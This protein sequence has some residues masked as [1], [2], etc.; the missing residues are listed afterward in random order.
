MLVWN[1]T[2]ELSSFEEYHATFFATFSTSFT[3]AGGGGWSSYGTTSGETHRSG[4]SSTS[5]SRATDYRT[6]NTPQNNHLYSQVS[7]RSFAGCATSSSSINSFSLTDLLTLIDTSPGGSSTTFDNGTGSTITF[8][9]TNTI[10]V[11]I[12]TTTTSTFEQTRVTTT[13][14]DVDTTAVTITGAGTDATTAFTLTTT[15]AMTTVTET[16]GTTV[17]NTTGSVVTASHPIELGLVVD[18]R[19][20]WGWR[21]TD[22]SS[23]SLP[24]FITDIG[25]S[26][27]T[28]V[29]WAET[30]SGPVSYVTFGQSS[31]TTSFTA[32]EAITTHTIDVVTDVLVT[33]TGASGDKFPRDTFT[34]EGISYSI[35]SSTFTHGTAGQTIHAYA[36][37]SRS[38]TVLVYEPVTRHSIVNGQNV[39]LR[40]VE[41]VVM[42]SSYL[43]SAEVYL[44]SSSS[45]AFNASMDFTQ[46]RTTVKVLSLQPIGFT[47]PNTFIAPSPPPGFAAPQELHATATHG[48]GTN[49]SFGGGTIFYPATLELFQAVSVP[50]IAGPLA[51]DENGHTWSY[52]WAFD[53][54]GAT[55]S[56]SEM[57]TYLDGAETKTTATTGSGTFSLM[58]E[59]TDGYCI[60]G[61][62]VLGGYQGFKAEEES[63]YMPPRAVRG[64]SIGTDG[65]ATTFK[66]IFSVYDT[67]ALRETIRVETDLPAIRP[68]MFEVDSMDEPFFTWFPRNKEAFF[69]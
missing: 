54:T 53:S 55:L 21:I 26:F 34:Y 38:T 27:D 18:A 51:I 39:T 57:S 40:D 10:S 41:P 58:G 2:R 61:G 33:L 66:S 20:V 64:S 17:T 65:V 46:E 37:T 32:P 44:A 15:N 45:T 3:S 59:Q 23:S 68:F 47:A 13:M 14:S 28:T 42:T 12:S 67:I 69:D 56:F 30:T 49:L 63:G 60:I 7:E 24:R 1:T 19:D 43:T 29:L 22:T 11:S 50:N 62:S 16:F 9:G 36:S 5:F 35:E 48:Y 52:Q 6:T 25:E 31:T 4:G 8:G